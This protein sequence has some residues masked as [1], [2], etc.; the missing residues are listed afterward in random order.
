[1]KQTL[2]FGLREGSRPYTDNNIAN[3]G[4][5]I[6]QKVSIDARFEGQTESSQ[7][8]TALINLVNY[9]SQHAYDTTR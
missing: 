4:M 2:T 7:I 3:N 9:A 5:V 1:M 8:E 6:E